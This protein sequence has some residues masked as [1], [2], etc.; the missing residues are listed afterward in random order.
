MLSYFTTYD[1]Y[2]YWKGCY[3]AD[4]LCAATGWN[5]LSKSPFTAWIFEQTKGSELAATYVGGGFITGAA[6]AY[7]AGLLIKGAAASG[8][9][10]AQ[11][12]VNY[13]GNKIRK[14]FGE[15]TPLIAA[16]FVAF[17]TLQIK[18]AIVAV[19]QALLAQNEF[20]SKAAE[21][22][23]VQD[24]MEKGLQELQKKQ[25]EIKGGLQ[26]D[27]L[28]PQQGVAE[29]KTY[30]QGLLPRLLSH[31]LPRINNIDALA[32]QYGSHTD[33]P[34]APRKSAC[35]AILS[36]FNCRSRRR[37][38]SPDL[39]VRSPLMPCGMPFSEAEALRGQA[40]LR[41]SM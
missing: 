8:I 22:R 14:T 30:L 15:N 28:G 17:Q 32:E 20:L 7:G 39:N 13:V 29:I 5:G 12:L 11:D 19:K 23:L 27:P 26:V 9:K 2:D 6:I 24:L 10:P 25:A 38:Q 34:Q 1:G 41:R 16:A 21:D 31:H 18:D 35:S 3:T 37:A 40:R 33:L 36:M 4:E